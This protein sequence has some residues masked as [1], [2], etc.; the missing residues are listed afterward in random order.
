MTNNMKFSL[1]PTEKAKN[2]ILNSKIF[3]EKKNKPIEQNKK[4]QE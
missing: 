1:Q 3:L 4:A 2:N